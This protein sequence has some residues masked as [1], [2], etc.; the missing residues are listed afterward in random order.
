MLPR[1][2]IARP[3]T[4]RG[5]PS[6]HEDDCACPICERKRAAEGARRTAG[7]GESDSGTFTHTDPLNAPRHDLRKMRTLPDPDLGTNDP[8]LSTADPDLSLS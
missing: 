4:A 6:T 7:E 3:H 5:K 8:D 1:L 2:R